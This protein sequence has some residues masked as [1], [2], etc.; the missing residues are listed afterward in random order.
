MIRYDNVTTLQ[1]WMVS[2][3]LLVHWW[4]ILPLSKSTVQPELHLDDTSGATCDIE[5]GDL[6]VRFEI[7]G[8]WEPR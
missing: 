2:H 8:R 1:Y 7:C 5:P 4:P 3:V 6:S